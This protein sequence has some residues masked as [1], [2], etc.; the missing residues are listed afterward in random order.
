MR[1]ERLENL[2]RE[3]NEGF[4]QSS[5]KETIKR[6]DVTA[7]KQRFEQVK[8][9]FGE[10]TNFWQDVSLDC[11]IHASLEVGRAFFDDE[12]ERVEAEGL[13]HLTEAGE[14]YELLRYHF[15]LA[16]SHRIHR[17][18][19][20]ALFHLEEGLS[21]YQLLGIEL[22][23]YHRTTAADVYFHCAHYD[24]VI[25]LCDELIA[26]L[27]QQNRMSEMDECLQYEG[28]RARA[29]RHCEGEKQ[30]TR[31]AP[32]IQPDITKLDAIAEAAR[33]A[34]GVALNTSPKTKN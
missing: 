1:T 4:E 32:A 17:R 14:G 29:I 25:P 8:Q 2:Q 10:L 3:W 7:Y 13:S 6:G 33:A 22:S 27:A 11:S 18:F 34:R 24:K 16:S 5:L 26:H 31:E 28:M 23:H 30:A 12:S 19:N 21:L 15:H 9:K 20:Q